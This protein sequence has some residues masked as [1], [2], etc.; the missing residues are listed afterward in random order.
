MIEV[1]LAV[2]ALVYLVVGAITDIKTREVPDWVSYSAIFAGIGIRLLASLANF[3]WSYIIAGAFGLVGFGIMAYAMFYLGQWGGGDS[4]LLIGLGAL[5]GIDVKWGAG[6]GASLLNSFAVAFLVWVLIAGA[7]YGTVWIIALA[8]RNRRQFSANARK[9]FK[10]RKYKIL[11]YAAFVPA[12][13]LVA[14]ALF[15][16][17]DALFRI[18]LIGLAIILPLTFY[19]TVAVSAVEK[20][21][22]LKLVKPEQLTEGDWIVKDVWTKKFKKESLAQFLIRNAMAPKNKIISR[23]SRKLYC[24]SKYSLMKL[25]R[26]L[27][28]LL[29]FRNKKLSEYTQIVEKL[30]NAKSKKECKQYLKQLKPIKNGAQYFEFLKKVCNFDYETIYLCGPKDLG[31]SKE[32][33]RQLLSLKKKRKIGRNFRVLI[34]NGIPFVPSFLL[35]YLAAIFIG[36]LLI[37]LL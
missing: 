2:L 14:I 22:M 28:Y 24:Y 35:A 23:V 36:N 20:C 7:V 25:L 30:V 1:L 17:T 21:C 31:I 37:L 26:L 15:A 16:T 33:I 10:T 4:K 27:Y 11:K 34:K 13:V 3:D 12:L 32:Q 5:I 8:F 9:L 29:F 19:L 18:P 6:F